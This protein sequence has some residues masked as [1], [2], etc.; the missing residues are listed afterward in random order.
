[1]AAIVFDLDG[2]LIDSAPDLHAIA[3]DLLAAE[4]APPITLDQ[5]RSFRPGR[6]RVRRPDAGDGRPA[7]A[8]RCGLHRAL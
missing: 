3:N 8:R 6:Q 5:A 7:E 4:G 2:T 1:M